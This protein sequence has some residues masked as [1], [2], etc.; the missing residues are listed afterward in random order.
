MGIYAGI[1]TCFQFDTTTGD[2]VG[3][4]MLPREDSDPCQL[5]L[6]DYGDI[7][8]Q[9]VPRRWQ[10]RYGD[11]LFADLRIEQWQFDTKSPGGQN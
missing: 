4:V 8:G 3:I 6:T 10:V 7:S 11:R 9:R 1:E 5:A 2:L